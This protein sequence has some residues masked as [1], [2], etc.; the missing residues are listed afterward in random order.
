[1]HPSYSHGTE[2]FR[3][4][5]FPSLPPQ[6]QINGAHASIKKTGG[7]SHADSRKANGRWRVV[8]ATPQGR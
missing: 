5:R 8:A 1:M 2:L 7:P 6:D 4:M 3:G